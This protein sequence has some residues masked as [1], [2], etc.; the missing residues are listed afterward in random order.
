MSDYLESDF[1][2]PEEGLDYLFARMGAI[3]G[4][5]FIRH[6]EGVNVEIIR[7]TWLDILGVYATYRPSMDAALKLMD[8]TYI[9]SALTFKK[10]CEVGPKIPFKPHAVIGFHQKPDSFTMDKEMI[11]QQIDK[12]YEVLNAKN[13][14]KE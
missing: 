11:K 6:W 5:T 1:C 14:E 13:Y 10:L 12:M 8:A 3:Y 9:P 4:A 2:K 7:D